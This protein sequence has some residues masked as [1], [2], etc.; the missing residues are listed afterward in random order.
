[1]KLDEFRQSFASA[2]CLIACRPGI[3]D[4]DVR[5][6]LQISKL[7]RR[8]TGHEPTV[9]SHDDADANAQ[10]ERFRK[11]SDK[12][13]CAVRKI[14]EGVDIK[15][16]MVLIMATRPTTEL[17]FRQL[18]GR[19][20]RVSNDGAVEHAVIFIPKFP[21]LVQWA[22]RI[23]EDAEVGLK[24]RKE[25]LNSNGGD[26][27]KSNPFIALGSEH[28]DGGAIYF[29][30]AYSAA[31]INAA[32]KLKDEAP[33][34]FGVA[35]SAIACVMRKAGVEIDPTEA[36]AQPLQIKKKKLRGEIVTLS[37][38]LAFLKNGDQPDFKAVWRDIR[39]VTGVRDIVDLVDNRSIEV[40]TQVRD[41]LKL[42][43]GSVGNA[44]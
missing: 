11:G 16:L 23:Q 28:K 25:R 14:S 4:G 35:T 12:F 41:L 39:G 24:Q 30:D 29:G 26:D 22:E 43:V 2:G 3:D 38:R 40:M 10:I 32:E 5:H 37:R 34:L 1:M 31:E 15:R 33:Q 21:Q 36:P 27:P 8:V 9:V 18:S 19:V 42:W 44:S 20:M 13:L 17:L 6:L 7:T